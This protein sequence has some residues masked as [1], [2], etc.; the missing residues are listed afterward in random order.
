MRVTV[1]LCF[2]FP[3]FLLVARVASFS[4]SLFFSF[5]FFFL[6]S[7][8]SLRPFLWFAEVASVGQGKAQTIKVERIVTVP[9]MSSSI[10]SVALS[11]ICTCFGLCSCLGGHVC[12]DSYG[13]AKL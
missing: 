7:F 6:F 11:H 9:A 3:L 12:G 1:K 5:L 2:C 8:S 13:R 10:S 4:L